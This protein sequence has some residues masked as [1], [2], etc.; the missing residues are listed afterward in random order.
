MLPGSHCWNWYAYPYSDVIMGAMASEIT[1]FTIVYS[2]V[3]L[4]ADQRK[5]RITGLCT[6]VSP[7]TG[8]FPVQKA[9]DAENIS[10]WWRHLALPCYQLS[11]AHL[12][13]RHAH[14]IRGYRFPNEL[15]GLDAK[16]TVGDRTVALNIIARCSITQ[17]PTGQWNIDNGAD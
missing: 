9:S 12:T 8:E 10:I 17:T 7:V 13:I 2:T 14:M 15:Q 3:Y 4:G 1:C 11:A 6:W 16:I 5:L